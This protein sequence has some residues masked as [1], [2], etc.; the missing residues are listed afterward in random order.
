MELALEPVSAAVL[1]GSR[2]VTGTHGG[3]ESPPPWGAVLSTS[4]S[5]AAGA[6]PP[7]G[8]GSWADLVAGMPE[9]G[10]ASLPPSFPL[11]L[12]TVPNQRVLAGQP[13]FPRKLS[14]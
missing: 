11:A 3:G 8:I 4:D 14:S 10:T 7:I 1:V 9:S 2:Q 6:S 5:S 13:T 12:Q